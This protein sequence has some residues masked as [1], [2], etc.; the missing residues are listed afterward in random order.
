MQLH[1]ACQH[2]LVVSCLPAVALG[3]CS[4]SFGRTRTPE[5]YDAE[6]EMKDDKEEPALTASAEATD[7]EDD[8]AS[9]RV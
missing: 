2:F 8:F 7:W 3:K 9:L 6:H 1:F 4:N 5:Q